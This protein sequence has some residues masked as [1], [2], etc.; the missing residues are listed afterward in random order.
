MQ[1]TSQKELWKKK[2][3]TFLFKEKML[4]LLIKTFDLQ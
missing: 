2:K 3:A 4:N 1:K